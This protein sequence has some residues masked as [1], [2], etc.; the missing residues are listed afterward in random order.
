MKSKHLLI[1]IMGAVLLCLGLGAATQK[2]EAAEESAQKTLETSMGKMYLTE[3]TR[4]TSD[5]Q[6]KACTKATQIGRAHV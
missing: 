2:A 4:V 1:G 6:L 3:W 5:S